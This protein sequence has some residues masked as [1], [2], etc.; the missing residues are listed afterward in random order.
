M[1]PHMKQ[2]VTRYPRVSQAALRQLKR[3]LKALGISQE[4]VA[5]EINVTRPLVNNVLNGR[6]TSR[7]VIRAAQRLIADQR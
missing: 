1:T 3:Q 6:A 4:T 7:K 2:Q 5:Q